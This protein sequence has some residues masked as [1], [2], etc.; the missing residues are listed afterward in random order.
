MCKNSSRKLQHLEQVTGTAGPSAHIFLRKAY[1]RATPAEALLA[2]APKFVP[3]WAVCVIVGVLRQKWS[4]ID[5]VWLPGHVTSPHWL[6]VSYSGGANRVSWVTHNYVRMRSQCLKLNCDW[7]I[8]KRGWL[9]Y[10]LCT[11]KN[12][13]R[14]RLGCSCKQGLCRGCRAQALRRK[15]VC[16]L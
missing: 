13:P 1:A 16:P 10:H 2:R 6:K 12:W 8:P 11:G 15:V 4:L 3:P 14:N 7:R 5:V 9:L